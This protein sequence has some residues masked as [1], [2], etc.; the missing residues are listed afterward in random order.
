M[1]VIVEDMEKVN[2]D[3]IGAYDDQQIDWRFGE[4]E[5]GPSNVR[6]L[7]TNKTQLKNKITTLVVKE[8]NFCDTLIART[9]VYKAMNEVMRWARCDACPPGYSE[10]YGDKVPFLSKHFGFMDTREQELG[11]NIYAKG[12]KRVNM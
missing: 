1:E 9:L 10:H 6:Y 12:N 11:F 2:M 4:T 8:M 3:Q 7:F 5:D